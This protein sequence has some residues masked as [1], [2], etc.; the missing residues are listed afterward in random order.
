MLK[1][2]EI[3][4]RTNCMLLLAMDLLY[5]EPGHVEPR[6]RNF[7]RYGYSWLKANHFL[8]LGFFGSS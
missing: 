1:R 6:K 4:G 5:F 8:F 3:F 7:N 2:S